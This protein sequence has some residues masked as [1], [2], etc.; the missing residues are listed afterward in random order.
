VAYILGRREFR[1]LVLGVDRRVL[2]PRPE[3]E[4]LVEV[5]SELPAGAIVADVGTGSG[6]VAL[7]LTDERPDLVVRGLDESADALAVARQ[8]AERLD[9]GV[10]FVRADLLDGARYDAVLANLPYV[11]EGAALEPEISVF[12]PRSALFAGADGLE[13]IRRLVA[14]VGERGRPLPL[15]A[16][17]ISAEQ[18]RPVSEL[19]AGVGYGSVTVRRDLAGHDRV[20]VG[21]R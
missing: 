10:E 13:V 3:T 20:V 16:L 17:E 5:G 11:A 12:E 15:L 4:L 21:T 19:L 2:I 14:A 9:L 18:A 6:A 7:A 8:N 1:R